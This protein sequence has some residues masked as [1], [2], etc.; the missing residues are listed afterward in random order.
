MT[1]TPQALQRR[2]I[3]QSDAE[4]RAILLKPGVLDALVALVERRAVKRAVE[5]AEPAE[6][7]KK[8]PRWTKP[9]RSDGGA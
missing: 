3:C 8:K 7:T 2:T 5:T 6:P 4:L 1:T 9:R